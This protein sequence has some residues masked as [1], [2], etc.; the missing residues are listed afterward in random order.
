M[1]SRVT[2]SHS[3]ITKPSTSSAAHG[4][5][6]PPCNARTRK[7]KFQITKQIG[8]SFEISYTTLHHERNQ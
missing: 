5:V 2:A 3:L 8:T 4:K 6:P 1:G 7:H